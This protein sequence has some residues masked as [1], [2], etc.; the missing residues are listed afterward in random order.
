MKKII[1]GI[2][3]AVIVLLIV[4]LVVLGLSLDGIV[5]RGVET[6]GP[7][8]TQTSV[9]LDKVSLSLLSGGGQIGGLVV[10]NPGGFTTPHAISVG[11]AT[12]VVQPASLMADKIVIRTVRVEAPEITLETGLNGTNLK[13][14]IDNLSAATA[15]AGTKP[16]APAEAGGPGKKLEVDDFLIAGAKLNF[17]VTGLG[18]QAVTLPEI[19]LVNLGQ[20]PEGITSA[21]LTKIVITAI[22]KAAVKAVSENS[23]TI[24]KGATGLVKGLTG[25]TNTAA[26]ENL[27]KGLGDMLK[28]K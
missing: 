6:V 15:S 16:A 8:L 17:S 7:K 1:L 5:K 18:A 12:L 24:V 21:E 25:N 20:G 22:E 10:G 26:I 14:I 27:G 13:K 28:K 9:T 23:D 19:H 4:G 2:A 3:I 11:K